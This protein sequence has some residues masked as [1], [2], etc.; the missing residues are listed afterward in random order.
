MN[1]QNYRS[2]EIDQNRRITS[3]ETKKR[4]PGMA[5]ALNLIKKYYHIKSCF[6]F[7]YIAVQATKS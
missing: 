5:E 1:H 7:S 3:P 2:E 6:R 4:R